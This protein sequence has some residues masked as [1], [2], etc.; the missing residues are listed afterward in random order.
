MIFLAIAV[1]FGILLVPLIRSVLKVFCCF[2]AAF[3]AMIYLIHS[4][5]D[6]AVS[7]WVGIGTLVVLLALPWRRRRPPA[8]P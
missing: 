2:L 5:V 6:P 8:R 3:A 4:G 7:F 1:G